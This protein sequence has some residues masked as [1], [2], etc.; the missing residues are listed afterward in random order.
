[1]DSLEK[2]HLLLRYK[3]DINQEPTGGITRTPL[4]YACELGSYE[5]AL[6]LIEQGA[7]V[8]AP[9]AFNAGG[10]ALQLAAIGG[11]DRVVDLLLDKGADL[12]AP[13]SKHNG[14]TPF[15]GATEHGR[16]D[17]MTFLLR[18][19]VDIVS[20]GGRQYKRA[21]R[22]AK[23]NKQFPAVKLAELLYQTADQAH[24]TAFLEPNLDLY[25]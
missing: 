25:N 13:P 21:I 3:A 22:F 2:V 20:D 7:H 19:G 17:M 24:R 14:R 1:M 10:T 5:I 12:H 8:N 11:H 6:S 15:E 9:A 16:L 23:A 4:Q 18:A